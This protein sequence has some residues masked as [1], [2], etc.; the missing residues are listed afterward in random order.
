MDLLDDANEFAFF[1][2]FC[3]TLL[4]APYTTLLAF[5]LWVVAFELLFAMFCCWKRK[6]WSLLT[7]F[8]VVA[9]SL[10][11]FLLGKQLVGWQALKG[12]FLNG[13]LY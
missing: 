9:G 5:V 6:E 7:R 10:A 12:S 4:T 3:V 13:P 8:L 11:G 2:A 1:A